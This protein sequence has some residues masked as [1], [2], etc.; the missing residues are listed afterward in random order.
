MQL[1]SFY[2][3]SATYRVRIALNLKEVPY[4]LLPVH[5]VRDEG[6]HRRPELRALNPQ[7]FVPTLVD[8]ARVFT[9]SL[10]IIEY[11]DELYP[12]P[13]LLPGSARDRARIRG[14]AQIIACDIHPLSNIRVVD[15]LHEVLGAEEAERMAWHR[16]WI[17]E[18]LEALESM[19]ADNPATGEFCHGD[20]PTLAD[21]CLVPQVYNAQRY[22]CDLSAFPIIGCITRRCL[23]IEAFARAAPER[24]PDAE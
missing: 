4:Q 18:G 16:R 24:Q 12:D 10:A 2:R 13:P 6:E 17:T 11:L 15:Y 22:Q 23:G 8:G 7:G 1:Y 19:L 14:L 3:S 21:I 5:L 20:D 9:Q